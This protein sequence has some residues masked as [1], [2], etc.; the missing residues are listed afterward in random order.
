MSEHLYETLAVQYESL[1]SEKTLIIL[2]P[3]AYAQHYLFEQFLLQHL[4]AVYVHLPIDGTLQTVL[5]HISTAFLE[6][7]GQSVEFDARV[8]IAAQQF[9]AICG[10]SACNLLYLDGFDGDI[11]HALAPVIIHTAPLLQN[12]KHIILAGRR[13]PT[14]IY[15]DSSITAHIGILQL[16]HDHLAMDYLPTDDRI[17]MEVRA[18]GEGNVWING[19]LIERW[20]GSLPRTL[21]FYF[22]DRAMTTRADIFNTF[23]P[24]LS[25]K[26]AT[27]VFHVTKSK[28]NEILGVPLM[29]Y[30]S[31]YYR[32][33]PDIDL[34]YDAVLFQEAI[35]NADVAE[36]NEAAANLF[37]SAINLYRHDLLTS[38][39]ADWAN[40]RREEMRDMAGSALLSLAKL[41]QNINNQEALGLLVRAN[42][43]QPDREDVA[44]H[45]MQLYV[46]LG[47]QPEAV[48]VYNK[49]IR[50]YNP[51]ALAPETIDIYRTI[52]NRR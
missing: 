45:L 13:F 9:A 32:I 10:Q 46:Q 12:G 25:T 37:R 26:E 16:E 20:E 51:N 50:H 2:H 49:L 27:N 28:V 33:S 19:K 52:Q 23:W 44:R 39:R 43:L 35:Q 5:D 4:D 29:T 14:D 17:L 48:Q 41:Q 40:R 24:D 31:G 11:A 8:E 42:A 22:I 34:R 36:D 21:F 7:T 30:S 3:S 6:Q 38:I 1:A 18:F 47:R 15:T